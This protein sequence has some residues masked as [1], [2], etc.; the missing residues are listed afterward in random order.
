MNINNL[1]ARIE[2][3]EGKR[4]FPYKDQFDNITIG[5]GRNL[6][7]AGL[8]ND[9][10]LYLYG[11]DVQN[12]IHDAYKVFGE[13]FNTLSDARQEVLIE[14]IFQLGINRFRKFKETIEYIKSGEHEAASRE[15]MNST[16]AQQVPKRASELSKLY[17]KG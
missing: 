15:M 4:K 13:Y 7:G 8:S 10:I 5:I 11:N 17:K 9:E 1:K 6:S 3:H 16:W 12:A 2:Q 14:M